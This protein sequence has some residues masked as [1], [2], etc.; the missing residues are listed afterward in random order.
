[1]IE[2]RNNEVRYFT[3]DPSK[4]INKYT[5]N[6]VMKTWTEKV[7]DESANESVEIERHEIL[8]DKGVLINGDVLSSIRFWIEEGS[9][10]EIEVSNQRRMAYQSENTRLFP[11]KA[12]VKINDKKYSFLLYAV[13]VSNAIEILSDFIELNYTGGFYITELKEM[14]YCMILVDKLK[15]VTQRNI[16]LDVAYLNDEISMEEYLESKIDEEYNDNEDNEDGDPLKLKFYQIGAHIIQRLPD[17]PDEEYNATFIVQT[18]S[19]VRANMIIEKYLKDQQEKH[20]QE[21]LNHPD[22]NFVKKEIFSFIEESK[23]IS[24]GKFIPRQFSE[25]YSE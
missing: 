18:F 23:I 1:M 25:T 21:S 5:V 4:M 15:S 12:M 11:Y 13:S 8:L 17:I 22:R 19:A 24:V 6:R 14:D 2:T 20:Y 3:S 16:E 9:I 10:N 7:Y